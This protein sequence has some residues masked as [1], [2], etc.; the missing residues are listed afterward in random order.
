MMERHPTIQRL[1]NPFNNRIGKS[2]LSANHD[3][4]RDGQRQLLAKSAGRRC[5]DSRSRF[6]PVIAAR[7]IASALG[8]KRREEAEL[9]RARNEL[10]EPSINIIWTPDHSRTDRRI[11]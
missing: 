10:F 8:T 11:Q 4:Q 5:R 6:R 7:E 9:L 1:L 3:C 2:N